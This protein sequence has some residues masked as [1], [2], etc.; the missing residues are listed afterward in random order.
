MER[1]IMA[2]LDTIRDVNWEFITVDEF[3]SEIAPQFNLNEEQVQSVLDGKK[4]KVPWFEDGRFEGYAI[5]SNN[6]E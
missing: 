5:F 3:V 4:V 6:N 1:K 2:V